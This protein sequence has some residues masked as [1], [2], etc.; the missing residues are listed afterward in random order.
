MICPPDSAAAREA[1]AAG[2][3]LVGEDDLIAQIQDGTIEFDRL[4][5]HSDSSAKLNK[6]AGVGQILG[7]KGLMPSSKTGT[8]VGN[9]RNAIAA[10]T[11]TTEYREKRGVVRLGIGQLGFSPEELQRNVVAFMAAVKKDMELISERIQKEIHEVV[12]SSTNGPGFSL[13]GE[14]RS[15]NSLPTKDLT[16]W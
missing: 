8:V 4:L 15:P 14:F 7:P 10:M 11:G 1:L 9:P 2:A 13:N 5:C 16:I 12:L 3:S 6:A